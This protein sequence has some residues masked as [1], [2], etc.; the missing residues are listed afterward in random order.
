MVESDGSA[1]Q[2][3]ELI[4]AGIMPWALP[5]SVRQVANSDEALERAEILSEETDHFLVLAGF[6]AE[7]RAEAFQEKLSEDGVIKL[8]VE[9]S[10][11]SNLPW[12][13]ILHGPFSSAQASVVAGFR[14]RGI[15]DAWWVHRESNMD[16]VREQIQEPDAAPVTVVAELFEVETQTKLNP[17]HAGDFYFDYC[18]KEANARERETYCKDGSLTG[19]LIAENKIKDEGVIGDERNEALAAYCALQ[20]SPEERDKYCE[21]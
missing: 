21:D 6:R 12:Y 15:T 1:I 17:P 8:Q 2:K 14:S 7:F 16:P 5:I 10:S 19:L 18:V 4:D 13:R 11:V 9:E 3:Q 20:A